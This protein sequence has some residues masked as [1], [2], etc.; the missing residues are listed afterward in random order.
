MATKIFRLFESLFHKYNKKKLY[1]NKVFTLSVNYPDFDTPLDKLLLTDVKIIK[2]PINLKT[3]TFD[4]RP[5]FE[6]FSQQYSQFLEKFKTTIAEF[7]NAKTSVDDASFEIFMLG[8]YFCSPV[9]FCVIIQNLLYLFSSYIYIKP[10]MRNKKYDKFLLCLLK[11]LIT[12]KYES[13]KLKYCSRT[14]FFDLDYFCEDSNFD[15]TFGKC[16]QIKKFATYCK[17]IEM[18]KDGKYRQ[19]MLYWNLSNIAFKITKIEYTNDFDFNKDMK[20]DIY[21]KNNEDTDCTNDEE[22]DTDTETESETESEDDIC[23]DEIDLEEVD[24]TSIVKQN[25]DTNDKTKKFND[26]D[27]KKSLPKGGFYAKLQEHEKEIKKY[28]KSNFNDYNLECIENILANIETFSTENINL[29]KLADRR[30]E[31]NHQIV[32]NPMLLPVVAFWAKPARFRESLLLL[33]RIY[34]EHMYNERVER[35]TYE[36][37][38]LSFNLDNLPKPKLSW[39]NELNENKSTESKIITEAE[40][41]LETLNLSTHSNITNNNNNNNNDDNQITKSNCCCTERCAI[42]EMKINHLEQLLLKKLN[43]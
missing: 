22:T 27:S 29:L 32:G 9:A 20:F 42:I 14:G 8:A 26:T 37:T 38:R 5:M 34:I 3:F 23:E 18:F 6:L 17:T 33:F 39:V 1:S 36:K 30:L 35:V 7:K 4:C 12:E 10:G 41:T 13:S 21:S 2:I 24:N 28:N 31:K 11:I 16:S 40:P 25:N 19:P 15:R 43:M